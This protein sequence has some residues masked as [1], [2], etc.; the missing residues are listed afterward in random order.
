M[1]LD[2]KIYSSQ[3]FPKYLPKLNDLYDQLFEG[4]K[5]FRAGLV[6]QVS[7]FAEIDEKTTHLLA[8][9][10]EFIHNSSLLH[11]DLIDRSPLRRGK[12]AA[13]L[14][15]G[16]EYTVLAGDY[17]L[18]RVI[19]NLSEHGHIGLVKITGQAISDLLE[20]EWL[21]D[22]VRHQ[23][24]VS[25]DDM[26]RIHRLKTSSLFSWCLKA[27]Y[28]FKNA[29][30]EAILLLSEMG[31][32]MGALLQRS[33]DLL[34]FNIRN[35]EG[36]TSFTDLKAGYLNLFSIHLFSTSE[37]REKA[38]ALENEQQFLELIGQENLD[39][40]LKSFDQINEKLISSI[41]AKAQKL[42]TNFGFSENFV[43]F[44]KAVTLKI[45]WRQ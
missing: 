15:F 44:V 26:D 36:K 39:Q 24:D 42:Q 5:G 17:L 6:R 1:S 10:V 22:S 38:Y 2:L 33:D 8:Q 34:D 32:E 41:L 40:A 13:W 3:D 16:P 14:E 18:A 31:D 4:G 43:E 19:V 20:G 35:F 9:T 12:K 28:V 29:S 25:W 37:L 7:E 45:Y 21:Q 23:V 11:D 30:P 27:P